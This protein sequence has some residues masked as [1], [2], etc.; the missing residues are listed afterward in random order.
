ME[1]GWEEGI[2]EGRGE[3][4]EEEQGRGEVQGGGE[5]QGWVEVQAE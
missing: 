4:S 1:A 3:R 5:V 2:E